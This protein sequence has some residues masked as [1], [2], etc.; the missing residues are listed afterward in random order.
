MWFK[1]FFL[2][3]YVYS[4]SSRYIDASLNYARVKQLNL[5]M[6]KYSIIT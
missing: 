1:R 3:F 2:D 6:Q 5:M 4:E